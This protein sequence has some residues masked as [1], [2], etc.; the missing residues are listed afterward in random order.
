MTESTFSKRSFSPST[1]SMHSEARRNMVFML[2][3]RVHGCFE[4]E[5]P[6]DAQYK[7]IRSCK[8]QR[9]R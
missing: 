9:F 6:L 1:P 4:A 3:V 2:T 7:R 5:D 8:V